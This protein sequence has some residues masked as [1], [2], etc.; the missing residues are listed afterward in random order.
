M[1]RIREVRT[2]FERLLKVWISKLEFSEED[3]V[4]DDMI[5]FSD[6]FD[7]F[8][9]GKNLNE[10]INRGDQYTQTE[11][12]LD[13]VD[14]LD[15]LNTSV[16]ITNNK[17]ER[18]ANLRFKET[19]QFE[20][21]DQL[22]SFDSRNYREY[23]IFDVYFKVLKKLYSKASEMELN[24]T[25]AIVMSRV[26]SSIQK[27]SVFEKEKFN[28]IALLN[29]FYYQ[30]MRGILSKKEIVESRPDD[31]FI[32][33]I[34]FKTIFMVYYLPLLRYWKVPLLKRFLLDNWVY[35][36]GFNANNLIKGF[37]ESLSEMTLSNSSFREID[38]YDI[39]SLI[40]EGQHDSKFFKSLERIR[41]DGNQIVSLQDLKDLLK[42][43]EEARESKRPEEI[44]ENIAEYFLK[45]EEDSAI[46]L[47]KFRAIQS[48]VLEYLGLVL[49]FKDVDFFEKSITGLRKNEQWSNHKKFFP[50]TMYDVLNWL[51]IFSE[52]KREMNFRIEPS[53]GYKYL[54]EI[55][56]YLFKGIPFNSDDFKNAMNLK[57]VIFNS[58]FLN[59]MRGH[60]KDLLTRIS[61]T[62]LISDSDREKLIH[63]FTTLSG[64]FT[65]Q[66]EQS[67]SLTPIEQKIFENLISKIFDEYKDR[68]IIHFLSSN[69]NSFSGDHKKFKGVDTFVVASNLQYRRY[70][71]PD[72]PSSPY[73][74]S[75]YFSRYLIEEELMQFD[76]L[77]LEKQIELQKEVLHVNSVRELSKQYSND[78]LFIFRNSFPNYWFN[79]I[80]SIGEDISDNNP[81]VFSYNTFDRNPELIIIPKSSILIHYLFDDRLKELTFHDSTLMLEWVDLG[82]GKNLSGELF[83]RIKEFHKNSDKSEEDLNKF[84][85]IRLA[86][87]AKILFRNKN[88]IL[89]FKLNPYGE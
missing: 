75:G 72:W 18:W 17:R 33:A 55:I 48:L 63:F 78:S 79:K 62:T 69:L 56:L 24:R 30:R 2:S 43:I 42:L 29:D 32:K 36:N 11:L 15:L 67:E 20:Y 76:Y 12:L 68:S 49:H 34:L 3:L 5:W 21:Y 60:S 70:L 71:I 89:R 82:G 46:Q 87:K 73:G 88:S 65:D 80:S 26:V 10:F 45:T 86:V 28:S 25:Q 4:A 52:V 37:L 57:G 81:S 58:T 44:S 41:N 84:F 83:E 35:I 61:G 38:L 23:N 50:D 1:D 47:Y 64:L 9:K 22:N 16:S 13:K 6:T 31:E 7:S 53:Y 39:R 66:I 14:F 74:L 51:M 77:F 19:K 40:D 85:W 59:S 54:G 27:V 8:F